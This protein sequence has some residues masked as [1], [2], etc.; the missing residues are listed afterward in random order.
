MVVISTLI[1]TL[2]LVRRFSNLHKVSY[3]EKQWLNT[4]TQFAAWTI[5][6]ACPIPSLVSLEVFSMLIWGV[7]R[8]V[9]WMIFEF[10]R[11]SVFVWVVMDLL[12]GLFWFF[13]IRVFGISAI[14]RNFL[15]LELGLRVGFL[16]L[17]VWDVFHLRSFSLLRSF[18]WE[19]LGQR[20]L[21]CLCL[22]CP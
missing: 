12:F 4:F 17:R 3:F 15:R 10:S 6:S 13:S 19:R 7:A 9:F 20:F 8:Q 14:D 1:F 16:L 22:Q 18:L 5:L 21:V 11:V 2:D